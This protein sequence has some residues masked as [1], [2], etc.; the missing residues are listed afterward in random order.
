MFPRLTKCT[1][2]RFGASGD[3]QKHDAMC[4]LPINILNEKI[5]IF[6]WFWLVFMAVASFVALLYRL[7]IIISKQLRCHITHTHCIII[8][9][10]YLEHFINNLSIGDWFMFDLLCRNMDSSNFRTLIE[11]YTTKPIKND[12]KS[13]NV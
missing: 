13:A 5:Y 1:F 2:H 10:D 8:K 9:K 3:V 11:E 4:I 6:L 12:R 7:A